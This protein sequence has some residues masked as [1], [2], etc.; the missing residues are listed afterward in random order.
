MQYLW[1][2]ISQYASIWLFLKNPQILSDFIN[3]PG[4][5]Q[6]KYKNNLS[7]CNEL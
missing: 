5:G 7:I 4:L 2:L 3:K 6:Y 1:L